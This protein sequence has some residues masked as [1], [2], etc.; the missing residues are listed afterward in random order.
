MGIDKGRRMRGVTWCTQHWCTQHV[1]W[2]D[3]NVLHLNDINKAT[4]SVWPSSS[5]Y[6]CTYDHHHRIR[7]L[8]LPVPTATYGPFIFFFL[9]LWPSS[10]ASCSSSSSYGA[11]SSCHRSCS[12]LFLAVLLLPPL[13]VLLWF[14][15]F[16]SNKKIK[17]FWKNPTRIIN[18]Y[19]SYGS[20]IRMVFFVE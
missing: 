4:V 9:F 19:G 13:L 18:P 12:W 14:F 2:N 10:S 17:F 6:P 8:L 15:L 11:F 20:A 16:V 3:K 7:I 5:S 1:G